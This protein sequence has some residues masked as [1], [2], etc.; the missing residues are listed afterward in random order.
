MTLA[1]IKLSWVTA[2]TGNL[3]DDYKASTIYALYHRLAHVLDY[4]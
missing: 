1:E 3:K 2:W 4:V